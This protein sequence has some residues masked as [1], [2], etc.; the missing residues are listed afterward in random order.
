MCSVCWRLQCC[1]AEHLKIWFHGSQI[2][3]EHIQGS[4]YLHLGTCPL[5]RER[6]GQIT[7]TSDHSKHRQHLVDGKETGGRKK[8]HNLLVDEVSATVAMAPNM[9]ISNQADL[10]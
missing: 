7:S 3:L 4:K 5:K 9:T 6:A 1:E 10:A 8:E 2:S